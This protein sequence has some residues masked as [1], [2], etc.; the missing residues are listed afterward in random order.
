LEG[1]P[2]LPFIER[3]NIDIIPVSDWLIVHVMSIGQAA[4]FFFCGSHG[5][6]TVFL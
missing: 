3:Y 2:A 5:A 1:C 4:V 6:I